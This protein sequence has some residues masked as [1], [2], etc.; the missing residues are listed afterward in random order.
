MV[1]LLGGKY[2]A[3]ILVPLVMRLSL[4]PRPFSVETRRHLGALGR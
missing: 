4:A 3:T 2:N 1:P